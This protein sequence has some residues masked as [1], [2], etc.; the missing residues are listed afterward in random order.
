M[1]THTDREAYWLDTFV[2]E[3]KEDREVYF[4]SPELWPAL[5]GEST[6]S[7]RQL[8]RAVSRDGTPFLWPIRLPGPDGKLDSWSQ[9]T[10]E[11]AILAQTSWVR[12][13]ANMALGAYDLFEATGIDAEPNWPRESMSELLRVAFR[14]KLI[15]E[16]DH[17]V[18]RRL[19]GEV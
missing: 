14:G 12:V 13:A 11:A 10:T 3:L 17:P 8:V 9:S 15:E 5:A 1:R 2:I 18:L 16:M 6:F 4:V 19:R 7:P